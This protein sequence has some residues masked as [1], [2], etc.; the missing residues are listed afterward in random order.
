[1]PRQ[2]GDQ[3]HGRFRLGIMSTEAETPLG[4]AGGVHK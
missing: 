1:M 2:I 3:D 4:I